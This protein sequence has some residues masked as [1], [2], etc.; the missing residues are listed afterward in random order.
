MFVDKKNKNT[1]PVHNFKY[2]PVKC[3]D[4]ALAVTHHATVRTQLHNI[5]NTYNKVASSLT[6]CGTLL[7]FNTGWLC[8]MIRVKGSGRCLSG[9]DFNKSWFVTHESNQALY[10]NGFFKKLRKITNQNYKIFHAETVESRL[11]F[12]QYCHVLAIFYLRF[13]WNWHRKNLR[14]TN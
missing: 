8:N 9:F 10:S 4:H 14:F 7:I 13:I 3:R 2:Q 12:I 6:L 1:P 11:F 5:T